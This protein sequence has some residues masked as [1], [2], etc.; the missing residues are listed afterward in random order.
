MKKRLRIVILAA[1]ILMAA[2]IMLMGAGRL[3]QAS[4]RDLMASGALNIGYSASDAVMSGPDFSNEY[5]EDGV[6]TV[7]TEGVGSLSVE[8]LWGDVNVSAYDGAEITF[9][10]ENLSGEKYA[11][12]Q[13]NALRWGVKDGTLYIRFCKNG[14]T[15][16]IGAKSLEVLLPEMLASALDGCE[17]S[18]VSADI[19]AAGLTARTLTFDTTSGEVTA[20]EIFAAEGS[21]SATSGAVRLSGA[22]RRVD[23]DCTSG[24]VTLEQTGGAAADGYVGTTSGSVAI[25]GFFGELEISTVSGNMES[26]GAVAAARLEAEATSGEIRLYGSFGSIEADTTSG[27]VD[28]SSDVCPDTA[29]IS[30][31]SGAVRLALPEGSGFTLRMDTASGDLSSDFS[32]RIEGKQYVAGNGQARME[33]DTTSGDAFILRS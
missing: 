2:G 4:F 21:A 26:I 33:I 1:G 13:D 31:T 5:A 28:I 23:V 14:K 9:R 27:D 12:T 29:D 25:S 17:I 18:S 24:D 30:T 8:W 11:L 20:E 22:F 6:Y 19:T 16:N 7:P 15:K 32:L 10:E 3:L